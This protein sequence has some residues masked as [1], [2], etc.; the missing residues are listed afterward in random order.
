MRK[1]LLLALSSTVLFIIIG[2]SSGQMST[3]RQTSSSS[4]QSSNQSELPK[5]T[6]STRAGSESAVKPEKPSSLMDDSQND[7][8]ITFNLEA[9]GQEAAGN[10]DFGKCLYETLGPKITELDGRRPTQPEMDLMIQCVI[11]F[12]PQLLY[13]QTGP[14]VPS[15]PSKPE[16]TDHLIRGR[17]T[18]VSNSQPEYVGHDQIGCVKSVGPT[19][20]KVEWEKT[21]NLVAG[22][23]TH[24][25]I[26]KSSPDS[27]YVGYDAND[28]SVWMSH[29][30]G[31]NWAQSDASAHVSG[32]AIHPTDPN[33]MIYS[34]LENNL[35]RSNDAGSTWS[36]VL[37][38]DGA[39]RDKS[40]TALAFSESRPNIAFAAASNVRDQGGMRGQSAPAD[41]LMS[42]DSGQ[43]WFTIGTCS[44]CGLIHTIAPARQSPENIFVAGSGGVFKSSDSGRTW[45]QL[46]GL[47]TIGLSIKPG[48]DEALVIATMHDGAYRSENGGSDWIG[49]S[50]GLDAVDS[51]K[52]HR[53]A[54][55]PTDGNQVYLTTHNG[56][57][58]SEDGG[59]TWLSRS[60]GLGYRFVHAIAVD[61]RDPNVAYVGTAS[62]LNTT[63]SEHMVDGIHEG[64]GLYKTLD[65]GVTWVQSGDDISESGIEQMAGHPLVPHTLWTAGAAGRG[66]Y[67][68]RNGGSSWLFAP[69]PGAHYPMVFD[70][71]NTDPNTMYL[72]SWAQ[73]G[74]LAKSVDGGATWSS[75]K[76]SLL[77]GVSDSSIE[78][79]LYRKAD[80]P[81]GEFIHLH[82]LA[83]SA[84]DPDVVYVGSVNDTRNPVEFHL[85]G[86]HVFRSEDSG[87]SWSERSDGLPTH[88]KTSVNALVV[89]PR[90]PD[91]VYAMTS[92]HESDVSEG[93]YK[94]TDG[95]LSW[96]EANRGLRH[97][98]TNDIQI[99]PLNP[100]VLYLA[101]DVPRFIQGTLLAGVYKSTDGAATWQPVSEGLPDGGV[102]DLAIDPASPNIVY[103]AT[104]DG[105]YMTN[106][107]A[108]NWVAINDGLP[109]FGR[110]VTFSHDRVLEIDA[111]GRSIYAAVR[112][113]KD[114]RSPRT[115]FRAIVKP[116]IASNFEY[117]FGIGPDTW[118]VNLESTSNVWSV[119]YDEEVSSLEIE[120]A[121]PIG[122]DG[123]VE[124]ELP[125]L[126][127]GIKPVSVQI[128]GS[129]GFSEC[130]LVGCA[131][132]YR[133]SSELKIRLEP[134]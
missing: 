119:I 5:P 40:F 124:F 56:V 103:A 131:V 18:S 41:V 81:G 53:V 113:G 36:S 22:G 7:R 50:E 1:L 97:K 67:V 120:V 73:G 33:V 45:E 100:D 87:K 62:E 46:F 64:E 79:G 93:L 51:M 31:A 107:G 109:E 76:H 134:N 32:L 13:Q 91:T 104:R 61:Q 129:T 70:F 85:K 47:A 55:A 66:A 26:S 2:C 37:T 123:F 127:T 24:I 59:Q 8:S 44:N 110:D 80:R 10:L 108:M 69:Y 96:N 65:G 95:G 30:A 72:T 16:H 19:C 28:M 25:A 114:A 106:D 84:S 21:G 60:D 99:D 82:G 3:P 34:V 48:N 105:V 92:S 102:T 118:S 11:E 49:S 125:K 101:M 83:V 52:T 27:V 126:M 132:R 111:R 130:D 89:D 58:K 4:A 23:V 57:F 35:Y 75:L 42:D 6:V 94:T 88:A 63:H 29:D 12:A 68:S 14:M 128:I 121:G 117:E 115:I 38:L 9:I 86:I 112:M 54:F 77:E 74:E 15:V 43:T 122:T 39:F 133:H 98:E 20:R 78:N 90:D 17:L 71:S 116:N